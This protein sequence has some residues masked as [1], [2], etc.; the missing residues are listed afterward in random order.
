M[1][2]VDVVGDLTLVDMSFIT[3]NMN[4]LKES[5]KQGYRLLKVIRTEE[6]AFVWPGG[7]SH[8][9]RQTGSTG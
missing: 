7:Y 3:S 4:S 1:P 6:V 8:W 2:L 9:A 5:L